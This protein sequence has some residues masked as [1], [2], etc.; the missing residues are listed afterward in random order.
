MVQGLNALKHHIEVLTR[1]GWTLKMSANQSPADQSGIDFIWANP[2]RG[3][4]PLDSKAVGETSCSLVQH[5]HVGNNNAAGEYGQL[6]FEDKLAFLEQLVTLARKR[7]PISYTLCTPPDT[8][9]KSVSVLLEEVKQFQKRLERAASKDGRYSEWADSLRGA[10]GYLL[11]KQRG[12]PSS[13]SI[14]AARGIVMTAVDAFFAAYFNGNNPAFASH[15]MRLRPCLKRSDRLV[16]LISGDTIKAAVG[17]AQ[18]LVV[19]SGLAQSIRDRYQ[20]SYAQAIQQHRAAEWLVQRKR[21]FETKGVELVI[22]NILDAFQ[23]QPGARRA[24]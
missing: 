1:D 7:E 14:Q 3:W 2:R 24:A 20:Q 22:H 8:A 17:K 21:V 9:A 19:L 4:F 18:E 16:Y 13:E 6:R 15:C 5:V 11:K 23:R 10:I 12:G